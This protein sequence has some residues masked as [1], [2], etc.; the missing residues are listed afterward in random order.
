MRRILTLSVYPS[1][2]VA[3]LMAFPLV[4]PG[5]L[6]AQ[7]VP[8]VFYINE[9]TMHIYSGM[10][11]G[12]SSSYRYFY[13]HAQDNP[14]VVNSIRRVYSY[15]CDGETTTTD[16]TFV[17][18]GSF[19]Q[20]DGYFICRGPGG[21]SSGTVPPYRSSR[22]TNDGYYLQDDYSNDIANT[23]HVM[24]IWYQYNDDMK[25]TQAIYKR[26]LS[27]WSRLDCEVDSLGR[28]LQEV[29]YS[30]ADSLIWVPSSRVC[31]SYTGEP[32]GLEADFEKYMSYPP[33]RNAISGT[34]KPLY[35][36]N[37][38][39][40]G[41]ISSSYWSNNEWEGD[42]PIPYVLHEME[43]G[44][45]LYLGASYWAWD[46]HGLP[47]NLCSPNG[48]SDVP[49]Y[50]IKYSHTSQVEVDDELLL[51]VVR[52][53]MWPNPS[54]GYSQVRLDLAVQTRVSVKTYNIKGQMLKSEEY[55]HGPD[56]FIWNARDERG[57]GLPSGVYIIRLE[58]KGGSASSRI[59]VV[60]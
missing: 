8:E 22:I 56:P 19:E 4:H 54:R 18:G 6:I 2:I 40:I 26:N 34:T 45:Y 58:W 41:T 1:F 10:R 25:L 24:R 20:H 48:Y 57:K 30:S 47:T 36:N 33:L 23:D 16:T 7:P 51:P 21:E 35:I 38:W 42:Y 46:L 17:F 39:K 31:Y 43:T 37:D 15:T 59:A 52:L 60:Q 32:S 12:S 5:S 11:P 13:A 28:R 44:Y 49:G 53:A 9:F 29:I 14:L 3:L 55:L 50:V 27:S